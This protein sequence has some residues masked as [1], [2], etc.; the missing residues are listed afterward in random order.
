MPETLSSFDTFSKAVAKG[1]P[2][3]TAQDLADWITAGGPDADTRMDALERFGGLMDGGSFFHVGVVRVFF[4]LFAGGMREVDALGQPRPLDAADVETVHAAV[5]EFLG[6][7]APHPLK[8]LVAAW[9]K[10]GRVV[11]AKELTT[12]QP[13][14]FPAGLFELD[15]EAAPALALFSD[16]KTT[17]QFQLPDLFPTLDADR[18]PLALPVQ[19]FDLGVDL[20][21]GG[22]SAPLALRLFVEALLM[23]DVKGRGQPVTMRVKA[24]CLLERLYPNG[25]PRGGRW[26]RSLEA[27]ANL[28]NGG[29]WIPWRDAKTGQ[30]GKAK[31]ISV[32]NIPYTP[33]AELVVTGYL[34][35]SAKR[36]PQVSPN[37]P[38]WG[39]E[40]AR[41][42]RLLLNLPVANWIEGR[43]FHPMGKRKGAPWAMSKDADDYPA[44][45]D[46][47][48]VR[49]AYP[50]SA[51]AN[52]RQLRKRALVALEKLNKA[53][54]IVLLETP[55]G[56]KA[57]PPGMKT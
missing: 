10:Q 46:A 33:D 53:G 24:R 3:A 34:P 56:T 25:A 8:P 27:A 54:E 50:S 21:Q 6:H 28:I 1:L 2:P 43:T 44:F 11:A 39:A 20:S 26:Q 32:Q 57:L 12:K 14:L 52:A 13:G 38:K 48:L 45:S 35:P 23:M 17:G 22:Q 15:A 47:D 55:D 5:V 37:L 31:L 9:V 19:L 18:A 49:M 7:A 4:R 40:S 30:A 16:V 29:A 41:A 36:G 42:Y 51:D